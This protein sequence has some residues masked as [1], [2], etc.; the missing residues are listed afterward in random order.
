[1]ASTLA[2]VVMLV[3]VV[4]PGAVATFLF[5]RSAGTLRGD[6]N[7]RLIRF[8]FASALLSPVM[9]ALGW[10]FGLGSFTSEQVPA[11]ASSTGTG[12]GKL[13]RCHRSGFCSRRL[14]RAACDCGVVG[15]PRTGALVGT[16]AG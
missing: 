6:A 3:V 9:A 10:S 12:R 7:D 4:L 1:M 15:R 14:G 16:P 11:A 2:A 8:V 13:R 5:E